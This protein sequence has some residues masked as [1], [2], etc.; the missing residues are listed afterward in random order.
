MNSHTKVVSILIVDDQQSNID[1]LVDLLDMLD[2]ENVEQ[3]TSPENAL[4]WCRKKYYDLI[5]LDLMMPKINGFEFME[6][7][8]TFLP[9]N[10]FQPIIVLTADVSVEARKNALLGG[11]S[12][13]IT[14][15]FDLTEVGLRIKNLLYTKYLFQQ[16]QDQN[17]MLEEKVKERTF[18]LEKLNEELVLAKDKAEAGDRLKTAFMQN[19]SHEVRTPL[20]GILG[21]AEIMSDPSFENEEKEMYKPLL[22]ASCDRLINTIT[23][24]MDISLIASGN[25]EVRFSTI[26]IN[27]LFSDYKDKYY[28]LCLS[29]KLE[30]EYLPPADNQNLTIETDPEFFKK[31]ITHLLDNAIKFTSTGFVKFGWEIKGNNF[32]MFVRDSGK[33]IADEAKSSIFNVFEQENLSLTRSHEGSGL[34]LSIIKGLLSL[35]GGQ[36]SFES[37]KGVGSVFYV[38]IPLKHSQVKDNMVSLT[39]ETVY[40][41][42]N[43]EIILI[44]EDDFANRFLLEKMVTELAAKVFLA[45][46]GQEAVEM[47]KNNPKITK[48]LMDLKMP[49]MDGFEATRIIKSFRPELPIIALTAYAMSGDERRAREAGCDD[50]LS[51]PVSKKQLLK[52]LSK[53]DAQSS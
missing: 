29:K 36:I 30:F 4:E 35:L 6:Q 8:K 39:K 23:D 26:H 50:Y 53:F 16:I 44:A 1:I 12:D 24:Y 9:E 21:F 13:F 52:T 19:I 43:E 10:Y 38:T 17:I 33:G 7:L 25:M 3:T 51:K 27:D 14:K 37:E 41:E 48:V 34:G 49:I 2:Y 28:E 18:R 31:I 22:Q 20:N 46:D 40:E 15:P 42:V 32:G 47:C 11:A 5:L 45:E